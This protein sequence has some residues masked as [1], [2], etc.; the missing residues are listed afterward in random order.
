MMSLR[1][2]GIEHKKLDDTLVATKR[3][4]LKDRKDMHRVLNELTQSIPPEYIAGPAFCIFQFVTSV[5]DGSDVEVGYPV[6]QAVEMDEVKTR[7]LPAMEVLSI[8]HKGSAE[9]LSESY[10]TLYSCASEEYGLI[11]GEFCREIYLDSNNPQGNEIEV[12]FVLHN[13]NALFAKNLGR[14]LGQDARQDVMQGS[15]ALTLEST[16]EERFQWVKG[17]M[18][19]LN[20]LADIGQKCDIVSN[21]AHVFPKDQIAKL[22]AVY[23]DTRAKTND[24]LTAV[25]AVIEF[26]DQDPGWGERPLREGAV[27][28]STKAPR[29]PQGYENAKDEAEKKKAYCF[30][31]LVRNH[32]ER[33]MSPTFCYCGGGWYRQQWEGAIGEPVQIEIVQSIVKGDDVC[34]FAIHLPIDS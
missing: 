15:D 29:N 28:Y 19:R 33:G 7:I 1:E 3:F 21:C 12:Q 14:V 11:S 32:L 10:G 13:W 6:T 5:Q 4:N 26:M 25:D 22:E 8:T 31:P 20:N 27:I 2:R 34:Q 24:F 23:E 9:R 18:E 30:C 17:A 16:V